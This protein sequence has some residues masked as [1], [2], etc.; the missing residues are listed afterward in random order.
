MR[1]L[2]SL[3]APQEGLPM[4]DRT[5]FYCYSLTARVMSYGGAAVDQG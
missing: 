5:P 4:A 1:T 3:R 2:S